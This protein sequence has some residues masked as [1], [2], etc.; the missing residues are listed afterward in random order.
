MENQDYYQ[1]LGIDKDADPKEIKIAYRKLAFQ[2]HPDRN[3]GKSEAA[4][5]MKQVNEAYAVLSD[6][7]KRRRYDALGRQ[8]G[9]AAHSR[10]RQ[11]YSE[12]DIF[13]GSDIHQVF[14]EMARSFG[15]RG[16]DEIFKEFYGP[17]YRQFDFKG[18]GITGGG[19]FF[20]GGLGRGPRGLVSGGLG[21]LAKMLLGKMGAG[22]LPEK[23][24]DLQDVIHLGPD[25]ATNGGPYAYFLREKSKK[26][27]VKIPPG[28]KDRQ[29]IRLAGMGRAGKW[30]GDHGDLYLE[31]RIRAPILERIKRL[32]GKSRSI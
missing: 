20:F 26:L 3:H 32:I 24:E 17:G 10:F 14:E 23:G 31:V 30:G 16:V 22:E 21:K 13:R 1:V 8:Y 5:R 27:V 12:Q 15:F 4:A 19:F 28:I 6:K 25:Q 18:P 7:D 9:D 2:Y 11:R 29:K